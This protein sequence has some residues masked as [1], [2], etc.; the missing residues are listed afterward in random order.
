[1]IRLIDGVSEAL[2]RIAAWLYFLTG[3]MISYEVAA[4][5]LFN[6]PTIWAQEIAQ[7]L[8]LWA[9]F[10]GIARALKRDQHIRINAL[11]PFIPEHGR[12][13][14][15]LFNLLFIALLCVLVVIYGSS[16]FWDSFERGRSTGTMLNI[17]NWW[18]E[19]VIP[20]GFGI[21]LLQALVE[22]VRVFRAPST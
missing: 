10:I 13:W 4:R 22:M 9:T 1:M 12:R 15:K 11:D 8:L 16:I 14:L 20:L 19:V 18:A 17:P 2:G 21:L 7:L 5:Y 3:L 6:A